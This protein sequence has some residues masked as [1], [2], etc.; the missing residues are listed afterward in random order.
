LYFLFTATGN[1]QP[2]TV[3]PSN[4]QP[5]TAFVFPSNWRLATGNCFCISLQPATC[6]LYFVFPATS[7]PLKKNFQKK[8][9]RFCR[10]ENPPTFAPPYERA[11][12]KKE[13]RK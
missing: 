8:Q 4:W 11:V 6:N 9:E 2:A 10:I 7:R 3:F 12:I 1:Q 13:K 5:A